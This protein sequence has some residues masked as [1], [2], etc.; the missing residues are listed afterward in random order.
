[1]FLVLVIHGS[2]YVTSVN[3][4]VTFALADMGDA[5]ASRPILFPN[6]LGNTP[7]WPLTVMVRKHEEEGMSRSGFYLCY[8][9]ARF[10]SLL[11]V[12]AGRMYLYIASAIVFH[13]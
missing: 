1:M 12:T 5:S 8:V 11:L 13:R 2:Q 7:G 9:F 3:Y 10:L 6:Q 4:Y